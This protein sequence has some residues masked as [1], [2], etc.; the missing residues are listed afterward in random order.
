M[1]HFILFSVFTVIFPVSMPLWAGME[2]VSRDLEG[3]SQQMVVV[4]KKV[5]I[6]INESDF[7]VIDLKNNKFY[8]IEPN[9]KRV[10]DMSSFYS[11]QTKNSPPDN[12]GRVELTFNKVGKGP[13][14]AGFKTVQHKMMIDEFV[15]ADVYLSKQAYALSDMQTLLKAFSLM[16]GREAAMGVSGDGDPCERVEFEMNEVQY[17]KYGVPMR[18]VSRD[19]HT[20]YEVLSIKPDVPISNKD[21][22]LPTAYKILTVESLYKLME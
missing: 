8:T 9:E 1:R 13:K 7:K 3:A 14:I 22:K 2:L 19:G 12:P 6:E 15:C 4:G 16:S 11:A 20:D 5:R 21:F 17:M 18:T 10:I